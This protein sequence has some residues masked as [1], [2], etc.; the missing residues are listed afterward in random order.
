MKKRLLVLTRYP[1]EYEPQRLKEAGEREN[2]KV[3]VISYRQIS[4]E[5]GQIFVG[6]EKIPLKEFSFLV[7][8]AASKPGSSLVVIKTALIEALTS[9]Q[10]CLNQKTF[11]RFPLTSKIFQNYLLS[12][13]GVPTVP[14]WIF[15][16]P[17]EWEAFLSQAQYPLIVK[18]AFGSHGRKVFV[19]KNK[20]EALAV[21]E[22]E[23]LES[24]IFQPLI[25]TPFWV[26]AL[27]L[28]GKCQGAVK[29]KVKERFLPRKEENFSPLLSESDYQEIS[30]LSQKAA[31][32][33][34][35]D[36]VGVDL[37]FYQ[38]RWLILEVNRTPQFQIF[39][40]RTKI[41]IAARIIRFLIATADA[42]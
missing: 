18:G 25:S 21:I 13:A 19:S 27:V 37:L 3:K 1:H 40:K 8:R 26:R 14:S 5:N 36:F 9:K 32:V 29:R 17:Q 7:P 24:V 35:A 22:K 28:G 23:H 16:H 11:Q 38:N 34:K 39:E 10:K 42:N 15:A 31:A 41:N 12:Q 20:K 6:K 30:T 33:L 4:L 2:L